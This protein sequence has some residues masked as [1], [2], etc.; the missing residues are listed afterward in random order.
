MV[1]GFGKT[2]NV[3]LTSNPCAV[4]EACGQMSTRNTNVNTQTCIGLFIKTLMT[5]LYLKMRYE[6]VLLVSLP[7]QCLNFPRSN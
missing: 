3:K 5:P 4:T 7:F 1:T 2:F 6:F